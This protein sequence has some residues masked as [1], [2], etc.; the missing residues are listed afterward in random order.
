MEKLE[1]ILGLYVASLRAISIIHQ[2]NHWLSK[3]ENSYGNHLLFERVYTSATE[4][5][6]LAAEKI[7]GVYGE[8]C[9]A[10]ELQTELLGRVLSKYKNLST[11]RVTQSV[12]VEKEF[13]KFSQQ[14]Y[15]GLSDGSLGESMTLG[16]DD[17]IMAIASNRETA[18]YLLNQS[19]K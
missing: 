16:V 5:L 14:V 11:D 10:Y 13:L 18:I 6:D 8:S 17:M 4:D 7:I 19:K 1:K 3:G 12:S 2:Q 9:L 15:D